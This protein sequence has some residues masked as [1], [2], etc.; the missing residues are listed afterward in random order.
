M[1]KPD[2]FTLTENNEPSP[3]VN[4]KI[5]FGVMFALTIAV[6]AFVF[7]FPS[8]VGDVN[9]APVV[10]IIQTPLEPITMPTTATEDEED[11]EDDETHDE[12]SE[13]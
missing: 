7:L 12:D 8:K 5:P 11:E 13:D 4:N 2:W 10:E 9:P 3:Y 6:T 1:K